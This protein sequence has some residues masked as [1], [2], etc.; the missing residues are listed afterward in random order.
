MTDSP[1]GFLIPAPCPSCGTL[2]RAGSCIN[3]EGASPKSGDFTICIR[4][5]S[6]LRYTDTGALELADPDE[7]H[8]ALREHFLR[9]LRDISS[10]RSKGQA[11]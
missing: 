9:I 10:G 1:E 4:C 2:L 7:L 8:M 5:L 11:N 6:L 3:L